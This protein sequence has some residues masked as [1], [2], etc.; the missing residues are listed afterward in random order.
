MVKR[1]TPKMLRRF[2]KADLYKILRNDFNLSTSDVK[3]S[4]SKNKMIM[5]LK[6]QK[7]WKNKVVNKIPAPKKVSQKVLDALKR[8]RDKR[9]KKN[10]PEFNNPKAIKKETVKVEQIS[11]SAE[12]QHN[13]KNDVNNIEFT[14]LEVP[15]DQDGDR[16]VKNIIEDKKDDEIKE[17]YDTEE[18]T[19]KNLKP[20]FE[21]LK[22]EMDSKHQVH[23]GFVDGLKKMGDKLKVALHKSSINSELLKEITQTELFGQLL[24]D[25]SRVIHARKLLNK[26]ETELFKTSGLFPDALLQDPELYD[27]TTH[28]LIAKED[29][30]NHV[31]LNKDM[32]ANENARIRAKAEYDNAHAPVVDQI[33]NDG[34]EQET[35]VDDNIQTNDDIGVI[36]RDDKVAKL[37]ENLRQSLGGVNEMEAQQ[38]LERHLMKKHNLNSQTGELETVLNQVYDKFGVRD[39]MEREMREEQDLQNFNNMMN[40]AMRTSLLLSHARNSNLTYNNESITTGPTITE[41]ENEGPIIE[42][43]TEINHRMNAIELPSSI[44]QNVFNLEDD[45]KMET[46]S[47]SQLKLEETP[48]QLNPQPVQQQSNRV[49]GRFS[50]LQ[51]DSSRRNAL[52]NQIMTQ[53]SSMSMLNRRNVNELAR[54]NMTQ[55]LD[56]NSTY[57]NDLQ[58]TEMIRDLQ[59]DEI[60]RQ[61]MIDRI[62]LNEELDDGYDVFGQRINTDFL[63]QAQQVHNRDINI[64]GFR[65]N[66]DRQSERAFNISQVE[67]TP[68]KIPSNVTEGLIKQ[69]NRFKKEMIKE[70][71]FMRRNPRN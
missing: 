40:V 43:V 18:Q 67:E 22:N 12:A 52:Q 38:K 33:D 15:I 71:G 61:N 48:G 45:M 17:L 69:N 24:L 9:F 20:L 13:R 11:N 28:D 53:N 60:E 29:L 16:D 3:K 37:A 25:L 66:V 55:M 8:G 70:K 7:A 64:T 14:A 23:L 46:I 39:A 50:Y 1:I 63:R 32:L 5:I 27:H 19:A 21:D 2:K 34:L 41:V 4:F 42:D 6:D 30:V 62:R 57:M 10:E 59:I 44:E 49:L 47:D 65:R 58:S 26:D 68:F 51:S 35:K 56:G 36:F 31:I 54:Q